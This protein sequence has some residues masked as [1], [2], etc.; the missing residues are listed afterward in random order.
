MAD[1]SEPKGDE[2]VPDRGREPGVALRPA[3]LTKRAQFLAVAATRKRVAMPTVV[4]QIRRQTETEIADGAPVVRYGLTASK[5]VGNAVARN[6]ARR[7]LR[8][9]AWSVLPMAVPSH[10]DVVL[11]ARAETATCPAVQLRRDLEAALGRLA[12]GARLAGADRG[13]PSA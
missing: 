13:E 1:G 12:R 3:V 5:K 2:V 9:L 11:I 6:R 8:A 7:R 10:H 4:V